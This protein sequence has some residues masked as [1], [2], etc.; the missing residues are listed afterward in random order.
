MLYI[1]LLSQFYTNVALWSLEEEWH[2]DVFVDEILK[3]DQ[4]H[5]PQVLRDVA[6]I[7]DS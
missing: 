2:K 1:V 6:F 3:D 4:I 5:G 7:D